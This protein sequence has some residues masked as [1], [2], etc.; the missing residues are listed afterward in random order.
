MRDDGGNPEYRRRV[1]GNWLEWGFLLLALVLIL[2]IIAV[3]V[4]EQK[5]A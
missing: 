1:Q 4:L 5:A 2:T 3:F